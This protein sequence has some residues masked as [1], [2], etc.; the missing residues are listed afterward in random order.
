MK[1]NETAEIICIYCHKEYIHDNP[2]LRG[3]GARMYY[4]KSDPSQNFH[5]SCY[6]YNNLDDKSKDFD[7]CFNCGK[8]IKAGNVVYINQIPFGSTCARNIQK[9]TGLDLIYNQVYHR[10]VITPMYFLLA[11]IPV[12]HGGG[13]IRFENEKVDLKNLDLTE[14]ENLKSAYLEQERVYNEILSDKKSYKKY[15][16]AAKKDFCEIQYLSLSDRSLELVEDH[17]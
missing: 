7:F 8:G 17:H 14:I 1:K 10:K 3:K 4:F 15:F 2:T 16:Q 11:D 13:R 12:P 6:N 9:D 5:L